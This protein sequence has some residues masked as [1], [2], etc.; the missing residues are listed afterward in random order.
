VT[1][2]A[3]AP[4]PKSTRTDRSR[5]WMNFEYVSAVT[6]RTLRAL[7]EATSALAS[8]SPYT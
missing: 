8:H 7:P 3:E 6:S 2:V 5:G 1:S 4:S